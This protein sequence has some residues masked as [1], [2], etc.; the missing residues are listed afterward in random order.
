MSNVAA[1]RTQLDNARTELAAMFG[2]ST[3]LRRK[4]VL[5]AEIDRLEPEV[6]AAE[7]AERTA[8]TR[9][10]AGRKAAETRKANVV[11]RRIAIYGL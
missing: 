10:E 6:A 1:L 3:N 9:K 4:F 2:D 7:L 11:R 5:R 8:Q